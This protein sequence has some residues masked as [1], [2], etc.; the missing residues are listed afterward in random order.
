MAGYAARTRV[1]VAAS[2]AELEKL[3][4]RFGAERWAQYTE[5]GSVV[6]FFEIA[7]VPYKFA[8]PIKSQHDEARLWRCLVA[9]VKGK[10]ISVEEGIET[11]D[12]AFI[13]HVV[14]KGGM[15]VSE[16]YGGNLSALAQ[17]GHIPALPSPFKGDTQ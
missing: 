12:Q 17:A 11:F 13:G 14:L 7:G 4:Q 1:P 2:R 15:T 8:L 6:M 16:T 10:L 3:M 5:K 9:S